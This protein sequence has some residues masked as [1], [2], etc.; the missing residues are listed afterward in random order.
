MWQSLANLINPAIQRLVEFA[1]RTP[2]FGD[3]TQTDQLILI[4]GSFFE[5]W[6]IHISKMVH[7]YQMMFY[8]GSYVTKQ[9]LELILEVWPNWL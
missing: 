2:N 5:I 4:K 9:Q 7:N 6:L 3:L 1:K 8:D